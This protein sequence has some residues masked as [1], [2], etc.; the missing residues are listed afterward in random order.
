LERY[1][2]KFKKQH[3]AL[4]DL[5]DENFDDWYYRMPDNFIG[6]PKHDARGELMVELHVLRYVQVV[7]E[8]EVKHKAL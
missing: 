7:H 4:D 6:R 2:Q 1:H 5:S 3:F 8:Q